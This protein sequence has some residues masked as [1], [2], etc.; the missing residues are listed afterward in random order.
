MGWAPGPLNP[1][2]LS[3][4]T[5]A[6]LA[7]VVNSSFYRHGHSSYSGQFPPEEA[8]L[9][10][11]VKGGVF[12]FR[13]LTSLGEHSSH[14]NFCSSEFSR[15]VGKILV[16]HTELLGENSTTSSHDGTLADHNA[17]LTDANTLLKADN[18]QTASLGQGSGEVVYGKQFYLELLA[19]FSSLERLI[20]GLVA[21]TCR[22]RKIP[23]G[24]AATWN[25]VKK[26][27]WEKM[28]RSSQKFFPPRNV[29]Q[30][31]P[32]MTRTGV[33][34]TKNRLSAYGLVKFHQTGSLGIISHQDVGLCHLLLLRSHAADLHF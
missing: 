16:H 7:A 13:G 21:I 4:K 20:T 33:L 14:C 17:I 29:N 9:F 26:Q 34:V 2:D 18:D 24:D 19:R 1:A 11:T 32:E 8:I 12:K 30:L 10:A 31:V 15:Q 27:V 3:S 28:L 22:V 6:N 25:S 5:H 23:R